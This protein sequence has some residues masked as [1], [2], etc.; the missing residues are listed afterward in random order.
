MISGKLE[1][2]YHVYDRAGDPARPGFAQ[3][4]SELGTQYPHFL[5][6]VGEIQTITLSVPPQ[7]E[8]EVRASGAFIHGS[9]TKNPYVVVKNQTVTLAVPDSE[10]R[11]LQ[12]LF[13]MLHTLN[14]SVKELQKQ[15]ITTTRIILSDFESEL[16]AH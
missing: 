10:D 11:T 6:S 1:I 4:I 3:R 13:L 7:K 15:A 5:L 8:A 9:E 14:N 2:D 12:A 16:V